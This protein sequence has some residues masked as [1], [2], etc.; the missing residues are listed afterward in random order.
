MEGLLLEL[1]AEVL[2]SNRNSFPSVTAPDETSDL[3]R[4]YLVEFIPARLTMWGRSE[5]TST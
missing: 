3:A 5:A 2:S 1:C 4:E